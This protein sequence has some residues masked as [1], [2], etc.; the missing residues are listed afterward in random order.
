MNNYPYIN[1]EKMR[2]FL[3]QQIGKPYSF[4]KENKPGDINA[5]AWDCSELVES[6]FAYIGIVVPDGSQNQYLASAAV[7]LPQFGDIGFF[8]KHEQPTHH[9]GILLNQNEVIEARGEEWQKVIIRPREKWEQWKDFTG[10]RRFNAVSGR[11]V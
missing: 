5:L 6:A 11:N 7:T 3:V 8:K 9:V 1:W 10:W 4:G 2:Q